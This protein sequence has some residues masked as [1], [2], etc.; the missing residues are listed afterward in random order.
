MYISRVFS[1]S[2]ASCCCDRMNKYQ[3]YHIFASTVVLI[4]NPHIAHIVIL[5]IFEEL[6]AF[7]DF[8]IVGESSVGFFQHKLSGWNNKGIYKLWRKD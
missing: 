1:S 4:S 5:E 3:F 8:L 2:F 7:C 6:L